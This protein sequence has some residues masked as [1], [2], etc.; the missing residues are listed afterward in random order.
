[1]IVDQLPNVAR[2]ADLEREIRGDDDLQ[3]G[4][5]NDFLVASH[6][7]LR[8]PNIYMARNKL[9]TNFLDE[10][11]IPSPSLRSS[12]SH[13]SPARCASGYDSA[14]GGNLDTAFDVEF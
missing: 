7:E 4:R 5:L 9:A 6:N 13:P 3:I 11:R 1:M 10:K 12:N 8:A 14:S 2:E